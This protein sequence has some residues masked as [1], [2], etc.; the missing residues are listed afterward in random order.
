MPIRLKTKK[1]MKMKIIFPIILLNLSSYNQAG[2]PENSP[3][4]IGG[5]QRRSFINQCIEGQAWA[6]Q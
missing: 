4:D 1:V 5:F 3:N 2:Y 6:K